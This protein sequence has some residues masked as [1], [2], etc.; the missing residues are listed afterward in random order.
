M[1]MNSM[2]PQ[3]PDQYKPRRVS[4]T[5]AWKSPDGFYV[6]VHEGATRCIT[7]IRIVGEQ[8]IVQ[9]YGDG[10]EICEASVPLDSEVWAVAP[11]VYEALS[12]KR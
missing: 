9:Y 12:L 3:R 7:H 5:A 11:A 2:L 4:L 10:G 1:S 8:A 6:W